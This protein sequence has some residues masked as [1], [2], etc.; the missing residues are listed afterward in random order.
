MTTIPEDDVLVPAG[1]SLFI[2]QRPRLTKLPASFSL[3]EQYAM[4]TRDDGR[5]V[6]VMR[7][8]DGMKFV[9]FAPAASG[10][11]QFE[12]DLRPAIEAL[13]ETYMHEVAADLEEAS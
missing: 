13:V 1:A 4:A 3:V 11:K 8:L 9:I 2:K 7:T 10:W 12:I 6:Q 5:E